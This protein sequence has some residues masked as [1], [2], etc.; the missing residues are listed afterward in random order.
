[1]KVKQKLQVSVVIVTLVVLLGGCSQPLSTRE[2]G[3]LLGGGIGAASGAIIGG[4]VG[5]PGAGAA[6][7]G[8]MGALSGG[9]IGD[10]LQG[11]EN[12]SAYQ[13]RQIT[14]QSREIQQQRRDI[15]RL[16]QRSDRDEEEY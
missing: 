15:E 4:A 3:T 6:I 12:R 5:H 2:K 7:G 8:A 14:Q 9:V 10:Q 1:M 11:Q 16:K 13:Q